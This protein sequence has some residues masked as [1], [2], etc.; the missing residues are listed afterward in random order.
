MMSPRRTFL[1]LLSLLFVL[2]PTRAFADK[3]RPVTGALTTEQGVRVLRLHGSAFDRGYSHGFLLG[4]DIRELATQV[5]LSP[6]VW[7]SLDYYE[8]TVRKQIVPLF[9]FTLG[10]QR[11]LDGILAGIR[12][13]V[14]PD[15]LHVDAVDRDLD[16]IDLKVMNIFADIQNGGCT[17]FAAWGPA[18]RN[19]DTI[20]GRNLDFNRLPGIPESQLIIAY[21][22]AGADRQ[23]W[24]TLAWPGM[25]GGYTALN[26]SGVF[27][28]M[29]DVRVPVNLPAAPFV[30]RA[31]AIRRI[32]E[33]TTAG[34]AIARATE[35]LR[36]S[37]AFCGNN[38]LVATAF[39]DQAT[40][41]AVFE[42]DGQFARDGGVSVRTPE[43]QSNTLPPHTIACTNHYRLRADATACDRY[44]KVQQML[45][46]HPTG[47]IDL[48][49]ARQI[50][51]KAAVNMTLHTVTADLN[52]GQLTVS[53][54]TAEK[55]ASETN[56][57]TFT[58]KDLL[59]PK[60]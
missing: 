11:E 1:A 19:G 23:P 49:L 18:T 44:A 5:L 3:R 47:E 55:N 21:T 48:D 40:P 36:D 24:I 15:K 35:I 26:A 50:E 30:P 42:Y 12:E 4:P 25:I 22:D 52:T 37:H 10:Q 9:S 6:I 20:V 2:A 43:A 46:D 41:A 51:A 28:S 38:F 59:T 14:G 45:V 31:L 56:P 33:N 39:H 57:A 16:V 34:D 7:P 27:V 32:M 29:H 13:S 54:C 53:F 58:L 17:S 8:N 60:N